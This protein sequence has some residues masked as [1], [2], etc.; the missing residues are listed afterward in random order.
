MSCY[1]RTTYTKIV[2]LALLLF[3]AACGRSNTG[4]PAARS[5][6]KASAPPAWA[7]AWAKEHLP[8]PA[9]HPRPQGKSAS[10]FTDTL[11]AWPPNGYYDPLYGG[12]T[13]PYYSC[14]RATQNDNPSHIELR[15]VH[16]AQI[17]NPPHG[18]YDFPAWADYEFWFPQYTSYYYNAQI[19]LSIQP[20]TTMP[21]IPP[22]HSIGVYLWNFNAGWTGHY[23]YFWLDD[24]PAVLDQVPGSR[25]ISPAGDTNVYIVANY[26]GSQSPGPFW[27]LKSVTLKALHTPE[28]VS[29]IWRT[30]AADTGNSNHVN[31]AGPS[32][33]SAYRYPVSL[34]IAGTDDYAI[35]GQ[36]AAEVNSSPIV[37]DSRGY[38]Y[39]MG[40]HGGDSHTRLFIVPPGAARWIN[41]QMPVIE[42]FDGAGLE[43]TG[44]YTSAPIVDSN[45]NVYFTAGRYVQKYHYPEGKYGIGEWNPAPL[46]TIPRESPGDDHY[47]CYLQF[48]PKLMDD[49]GTKLA[50]GLIFIRMSTGWHIAMDTATGA[51][52]WNPKIDVAD[53]LRWR[54]IAYGSNFSVSPAIDASPGYYSFLRVNR[55][56]GGSPFLVCYHHYYDSLTFYHQGVEL[57]W[58]M[59][60]DD[61][62]NKTGVGT[63]CIFKGNVYVLTQ[64]PSGSEG[65]LYGVKPGT[66]GPLSGGFAYGTPFGN[67]AT[68]PTAFTVDGRDVV[69]VADNAASGSLYAVGAVDDARAGTLV[70]S[71][72]GMAG[73]GAAYHVPISGS[74][75][76]VYHAGLSYL[77]GYQL[78][79]NGSWSFSQIWNQEVVPMPGYPGDSQG[80]L[81]DYST[82]DSKHILGISLNNLNEL[83]VHVYAMVSF[84]SE[85]VGGG[86]GI[87]IEAVR[88]WS[89][90]P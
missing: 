89:V 33:S 23:D 81:A 11:P 15:P 79:Y 52:V 70:A 85:A 4:V 44:Q 29:S 22:Y 50:D 27:E 82:C 18:S 43:G 75:G 71:A 20:G 88:P 63:P 87:C 8:A 51:L 7:A 3:V 64:A 36:L 9:E 53:D 56:Q 68:S 76:M 41:G 57:A 10:S 35:P 60:L 31:V 30:G 1:H 28:S 48:G 42:E 55:G 12:H 17:G 78:D 14:T 6:A 38:G 77:Y 84:A 46:P 61:T 74:G 37:F 54:E 83:G 69:V 19:E 5:Q 66:S 13:D 58:S 34:K 2:F 32:S 67:S 26:D 90:T 24:L 49:S 25:Y 47:D 39:F 72:G 16:N 65:V 21:N 73:D 80:V 40:N 86:N 45:D 59:P 62:D